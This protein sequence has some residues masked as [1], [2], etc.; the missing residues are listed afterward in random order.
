MPK[1]LR[2]QPIRTWEAGDSVQGF[3]LLTR[4][5]LR[6]DRNGK[7]FMDLEVTDASGSMVAKIWSDSP[8]LNGR[9]EAHQ[10]I[11][12]R[13][14]VKNYRDQL[15]LTIDDC[16]EATES[17]RHYG[18][19][20]S[21]LVPSTREDIDDLWMRL[22]RVYGEEVE[23]PVMRRLAAETLAVHGKALREHPAAKSM[24]HAYRGGLL[25]HVVSM[26]ELALLVCRHYADLDR[27]LVLLGVLF[28][29][30]GKLRELGAM[31]ANDYTLE[32]R[33]VGHVVIGRDLLIERCAAIE[34]FPD[35][36]RLLLEHLVL[37]H[38]GKKEFA[39]PVEPMT[40][41]ALALH[42]ID[43]LDSK[44]NQLRASRE[45][46][47]GMQYHRGL[48]RFVYLPPPPTPDDLLAQQEA[49]AIEAISAEPHALEVRE[50]ETPPDVEAEEPPDMLQAEEPEE[51][52]QAP[53]FQ[54]E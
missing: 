46:S 23:R 16:R 30:L 43:D 54:G 47:T 4:K 35:D 33:L 27:D 32:G 31:P 13:G 17:D 25:E 9:F 44:V 48:G 28:H 45:A 52:V 10:F 50:M 24:H 41:E 5:E 21:K 37:S 49:A 8:A 15:Q 38:Q 7:S 1:I 19:D 29:D 39:S 20:E 26:A 3:A 6:Q 40:P 53:L 2:N 34:G 22:Q 36:L 11:A 42:F 18:F 51:E 12:F 14:S